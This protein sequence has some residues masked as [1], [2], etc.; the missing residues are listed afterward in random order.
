MIHS[1]IVPQSG[2]HQQSPRGP[3]LGVSHRT[4]EI[5]PSP[6]AEPCQRALS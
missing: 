1:L 3:A 6:E 2:S 5:S 4:T